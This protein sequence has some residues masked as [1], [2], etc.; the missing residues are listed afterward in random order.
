[1]AD[2]YIHP[3]YEVDTRDALI[4]SYSDDRQASLACSFHSFGGQSAILFGDE[5][6][7]VVPFPYH[8]PESNRFT[9]YSGNQVETYEFNT[10][11]RP[12]APAIE[13]FHDCLLDGEKPIVTAEYAA[14]TSAI[15]NAAWESGRTGR[16][17]AI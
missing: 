9:V 8:P 12:F 16:R 3:K 15:I 11:L 5:G 6:H 7:I 4:L 14:G 10:G 2:T 13:H 1:M 17:V